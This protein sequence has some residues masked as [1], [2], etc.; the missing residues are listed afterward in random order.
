MKTGRYRTTQTNCECDST[1]LHAKQRS[2]FESD[3]ALP[4]IHNH[5]CSAHHSFFSYCTLLCHELHPADTALIH[6]EIPSHGQSREEDSA[7]EKGGGGGGVGI[8]TQATHIP[9]YQ[10]LLTH[11]N[12]DDCQMSTLS[13][14]DRKNGENMKGDD[15]SSRKRGNSLKQSE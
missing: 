8:Q 5:A 6:C 14:E 12:T 9:P 10:H 13:T 11:L 4:S 3:I 1:E 7:I 2:D 15:F